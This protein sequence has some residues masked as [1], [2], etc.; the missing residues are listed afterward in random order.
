MR[1]EV[2]N[3][4]S[5]RAVRRAIEFEIERH[6]EL[7]TAGQAIA[8]ETRS[9]DPEAE[10][11]LAMRD[12][13]KLQDYRY[14]PE[15]NLPPLRL[16]KAC[17]QPH[18][19]KG[20]CPVCVTCVRRS[21]PAQLP[22]LRRHW[23]IHTLAVSLKQS[24]TMLENAG[25]FDC[26]L[27]AMRSGGHDVTPQDDDVSAEAARL[28]KELVYWLTGHC[29]GELRKVSAEPE[30]LGQRLTPAQ[31]L[32]IAQGRLSGRLTQSDAKT[33]ISLRIRADDME[34]VLAAVRRCCEEAVQEEAETL[35]LV[36]AGK[37]KAA[38]FLLRKAFEKEP[39]L[40]KNMITAAMAELLKDHVTLKDLQPR[41]KGR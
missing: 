9:Y 8:N 5:L 14:C 18:S 29:L 41:K 7:L 20:G 34:K 24:E 17:G 23:L 2:K 10:R 35:A 4:N 26:F 16:Q 15:P 31:L 32:D 12:K 27:E 19:C 3:L 28:G 1:S 38:R 40:D 6:I 13:E 30:T 25:F 33:A 22:T 11:T 37:K 21:L 39:G 36:R